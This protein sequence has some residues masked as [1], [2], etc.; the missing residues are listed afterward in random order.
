MPVTGP[1]D[2]DFRRI[3]YV[4]AIVNKSAS[5]KKK[6]GTGPESFENSCLPESK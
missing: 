1:G 4:D 6:L 2:S 5:K 3:Q